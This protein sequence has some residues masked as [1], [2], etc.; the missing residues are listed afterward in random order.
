MGV[1]QVLIGIDQLGNTLLGGYADETISSRSWRLRLAS[2]FWGRMF[3]VV[4]FL[5]GKGHCEDAYLSEELRRQAPPA[6]RV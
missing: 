3:K 5:F 4:E 6:L 2:Q 1:K